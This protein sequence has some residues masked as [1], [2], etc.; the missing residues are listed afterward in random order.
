MGKRK[1]PAIDPET[2]ARWAEEQRELAA[3]V[4]QLQ[5]SIQE[6]RERNERRRARRRRLS[7]GLLG[8]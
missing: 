4:E 3:R 7:F 5:A 1:K 2:R 6:R 8:R